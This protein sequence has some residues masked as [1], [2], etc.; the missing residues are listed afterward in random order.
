VDCGKNLE[1]SVSINEK[2]LRGALQKKARK[3]KLME[4]KNPWRDPKAEAKH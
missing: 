1:L 2:A 4:E 3:L